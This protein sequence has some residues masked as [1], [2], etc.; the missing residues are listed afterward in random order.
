VPAAGV[1][2]AGVAGAGGTAATGVAAVAVA[3]GLVWLHAAS[4]PSSRS[5]V[6]VLVT[7]GHMKKVEFVAVQVAEVPGGP[8]SLPP[9]CRALRCIASTLAGLSTCSATMTSLPTV[10]TLLSK[11][12]AMPS[13]G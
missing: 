2:A 3:F 9:S 5:A 8:S 12:L 4:R 10:A 7:S 13:P 11:G 6:R 1:T